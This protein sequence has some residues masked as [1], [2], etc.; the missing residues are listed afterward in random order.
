M[1]RRQFITL[2]GGAAAWPVTARAQQQSMP[3]VGFLN[4]AS[5]DGYANLV[6]AFRDGLKDAGFVEGQNVAIEFR[7]ANEEYDRLPALAADLVQR[8]VT[9]IVATGIGVTALAAKAATTTIPIV[10]AIGADPLRNGLV[11]S[12]SRPEGNVTGATLL[13]GELM[14]KRL[15]L[16]HELLPTATTIGLLE[17]PNNPTHEVTARDIDAAARTLGLRTH[18]VKATSEREFDAAFISLV[19]QRVDG[20]AVLPDSLFTAQ[21]GRLVA[22]AARHAIPAIFPASEFSA[23][24]G[25]VSYGA[26]RPATYRQAGTYVGRILKGEH[27][28]DLPVLQPTKFEFII[29][30]KTAKTLGLTV[31]NQMQLLADEVIE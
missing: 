29:N 19:E 3:V 31:S 4:S 2:L 8:R 17:N 28:A 11:A 18:F 21:R 25:L 6:V 16:L 24:G 1:R 10:F 9:V 15:G 30:L 12:L 5:A 20:L 26:D 7:W 14:P 13:D 23:V 27:P 22:L